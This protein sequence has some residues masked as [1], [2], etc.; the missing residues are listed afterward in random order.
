MTIS[1]FAHELNCSNE[2]LLNNQKP[3]EEFEHLTAKFLGRRRRGGGEV[4][5]EN[6]SARLLTVS[7]C[8]TIDA[9]L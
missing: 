7:I 2:Q 9:E 3:A 5:P 4:A 8:D 1:T 6:G